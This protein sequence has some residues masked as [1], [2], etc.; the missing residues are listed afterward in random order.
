[1]ARAGFQARLAPMAVL[2]GFA[3]VFGGAGGGAI[4]VGSRGLAGYSRSL[5]PARAPRP[6]RRSASCKR[7]LSTGFVK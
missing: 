3:A 2:L 6:Q 4:P 5:F 1:M 7:S